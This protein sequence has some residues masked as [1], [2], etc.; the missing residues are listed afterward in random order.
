MVSGKIKFADLVAME[1]P[2]DVLR[3]VLAIFSS[4]YPDERPSRFEM[5]FEDTLALF[6]G[7]Y[8]GYQPCKTPFHDLR[9]TTDV[10][11][12]TARILHGA[13]CDKVAVAPE[14]FI[15]GLVGALMH[16]TGYIQSNGDRGG[17]GARYTLDHVRRSIDFMEGYFKLKGFSSDDWH[18]CR[19]CVLCTD[20]EVDIDEIAFVD[21]G[22]GFL[23]RAL[24]AADL[25]GQ[26]ADRTYLEKLPCLYEEF[27]EGGVTGYTSD[28]DLVMKT[29]AFY[30]TT[31]KRLSCQLAGVHGHL[32]SHFRIRFGIDR[33][34]YGEAIDNQIGYMKRVLE[35]HRAA[36]REHFHRRRPLRVLKSG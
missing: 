15:L 9:H 7:T 28:L 21:P 20:L 17:T 11:L 24:G 2:Y 18:L 12:A 34:L 14:R 36:Y 8:P 5:V 19:D 1:Q 27:L 13:F 22:H 10:F 35:R 23:G 32:R 30:E 29:A 33:D 3:E 26:M 6:G 4:M 16:D 25:L 31:K